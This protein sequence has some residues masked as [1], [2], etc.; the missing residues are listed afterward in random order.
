M[1]A[2]LAELSESRQQLVRHCRKN[3]FKLLEKWIEQYSDPIAFIYEL[4]QNAD[5]A[6]ASEVVCR[7]KPNQF[8]FTHDGNKLFTF[9][10]IDAITA[11][12]ASTKENDVN[13]IG[14][15][16]VGFK[17][18]FAIT[19]T[20]VIQSGEWCFKITGYIVPEEEVK[21]TDLKNK[22]A[23]TLP[24]DHDKHKPDKLYESIS[25]RLTSLQAESL[26]FLKHIKKI[27][28]VTCENEGFYQI[29]DV[30]ENRADICTQ[31]TDKTRHYL[32]FNKDVTVGN[33]NLCMTIA[34]R[35][36]TSKNSEKI[37]PED[38]PP[39]FVFFPSKNDDIRLKFLAHIPYKTIPSREKVKFDDEEN[40]ILTKEFSKFVI[41]TVESVKGM[42]L[43][44]MDFLALLPIDSEIVRSDSDTNKKNPLYVAIFTELKEAISEK[45]LL[46][47]SNG[48]Y[49]NAQNVLLA[50][51]PRVK[52][53]LENP[54]DIELLFGRKFWLESITTNS[55]GNKG[56]LSAY[57]E[58]CVRVPSKTLRNFCEEISEEFMRRKS[59][60][61]IIECFKELKP[62]LDKYHRYHFLLRLLKCRPIIRL[63]DGSHICPVNS[64]R[65]TTGLL[66]S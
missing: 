47:I 41:E 54:D 33:E 63:E 9:D 20:P 30:A 17:S 45:N 11:A 44:D 50:D 31:D 15:F 34:Y 14:K 65:R 46:P 66:A 37:I 24:F 51:G 18:V 6:Q 10:D 3:N 53:L 64:K 1:Y 42:K 23:F 52:K 48:R 62:I 22:T 5:D 36:D 16:G 25:K 61:W 12:G 19:K 59:D 7:L 21:T 32:T 57:L 29:D 58:H 60:E 13:T 56:Q 38:N 27:N 43:L 55:S 2:N 40:Q 39:L 35:L 28:W 8:E 49:A 26:L 4:L